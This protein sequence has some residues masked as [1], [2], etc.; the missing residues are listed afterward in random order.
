[1]S[2]PSLLAYAAAAVL[3]AWGAAHLAPTRAVADGFGGISTENR[4]IL[5]MEWIAEGIMHISIGMLVVLIT[6]SEGSGDTASHLV[7]RVAAAILVVLAALT[8]A[9]GAR[10][11]IVWFRI[12]PFVLT[13]AAV[14]L[15][16]ASAI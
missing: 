14:L 10:T 4:R 11:P 16:L 3:I 5:V 9:T 2:A 12:C 7:Y 1:V 15:L 13:G 6:A 8:A